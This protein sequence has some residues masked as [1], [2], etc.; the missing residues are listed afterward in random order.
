MINEERY[1]IGVSHGD[2]LPADLRIAAEGLLRKRPT[3]RALESAVRSMVGSQRSANVR[4]QLT[5]SAPAKSW[6]SVILSVAGSIALVVI[7]LGSQSQAWASVSIDLRA[8]RAVELA[9]AP[10]TVESGGRLIQFLLLLHIVSVVLA[11]LLILAA[12]LLSQLYAFA[13]LRSDSLRLARVPEPIVERILSLAIFF[14]LMGI[15]LGIVWASIEWGR[16]WGWDPRE[17]VALL[18]VVLVSCW[19]AFQKS[20]PPGRSAAQKLG[21]VATVLF[22]TTFLSLQLAS[23]QASH[24]HGMMWLPTIVLGFAAVNL[25]CNWVA[26]IIARK[27]SDQLTSDTTAGRVR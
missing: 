7:W 14:E 10:A 18:F 4:R 9:I 1:L 16:P 17:S 21:I 13:N 2:E 27:Q 22:W 6:Y 3:K 19:L 11:F 25:I 15:A 5:E 26:L 12:W 20:S 23:M 24:S 8:A